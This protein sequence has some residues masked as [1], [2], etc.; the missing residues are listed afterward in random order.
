MTLDSCDRNPGVVYECVHKS[1]RC[2]WLL[3]NVHLR[4]AKT[5]YIGSLFVLAFHS[6]ILTKTT[7]LE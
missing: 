1:A 7:V 6:Y 5:E 4:L 3:S 2:S